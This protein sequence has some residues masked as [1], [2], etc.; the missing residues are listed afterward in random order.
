MQMGQIRGEKV[1]R[2]YKKGKKK[3]RKET[4]R[5]L[6]RWWEQKRV[7]NSDLVTVQRAELIFEKSFKF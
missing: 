1:S 3:G 4:G 2:V 7:C 5:H 6:K